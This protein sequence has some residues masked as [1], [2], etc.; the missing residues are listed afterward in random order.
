MFF[1]PRGSQNE[2]KVKADYNLKK[3]GSLFQLP[4]MRLGRTKIRNFFELSLLLFCFPLFDSLYQ[5]H[6]FVVGNISCAKENL[7]AYTNFRNTET[8]LKHLCLRSVD[9]S[10]RLFSLSF[11]Q[12]VL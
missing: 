7:L 8:S 3:F 2:G 10:R 5:N 9:V 1:R 11:T 4:H 6:P 12:L